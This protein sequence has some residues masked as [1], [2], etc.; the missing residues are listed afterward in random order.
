M[1]AY[2]R[3]LLLLLF[4]T[5]ANRFLSAPPLM[6]SLSGWQREKPEN[7]PYLRKNATVGNKVRIQARKRYQ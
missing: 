3:F 1:Y 4:R 6:L 2:G 7:T 5:R